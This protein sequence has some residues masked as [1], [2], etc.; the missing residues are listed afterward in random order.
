MPGTYWDAVQPYGAEIFLEAG[1]EF[2]PGDIELVPLG[3]FRIEQASQQ[4]APFGPIELTCLDRIAQ[5]QQNQLMLPLPI[6]D[7]NTHR[8]VFEALINGINI[9][10]QQTY[11]GV[12]PAGNPAY[13]NG[14]VPI[15]WTAYNPDKTVIVGDQ[16]VQ[17][18]TY[19][20]LADLI[21]IYNAA[22]RFTNDGGMLVY[23]LLVDYSVPKATLTAGKGGTIL[24]A[25]RITKRTDVHNIVT[26]Y[27]TDPSSITDFIVSFNADSSS[28]LAWNS[29]TY[30]NVF[31]P[32]PTYYSSPLLQTDGDVILAGEALLRRYRALPLVNT[33]QVISN[34]AIEPFDPID[35]VLWPG[36]APVRAIV[37]SMIIPLSYD[38]PGTIVT[39]IPL[40]TEGLQ[41][42]L[43]VLQ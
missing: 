2:A 7:G 34:P 24:S 32:S 16:I 41:L 19:G 9:P 14:R 20:F 6:S 22:I 27:G 38:T 21:H 25:Q 12:V 5:I 37:D 17:D 23:S 15:T 4:I 1:V 30:P 8:D 31:G 28:P 35:V 3:Y 36:M 13:L 11:P 29:T 26:A 10:A 39:R 42:G 40:A 43:G 33:L 18:S